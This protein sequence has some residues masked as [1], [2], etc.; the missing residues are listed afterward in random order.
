MRTSPLPN[1]VKL[2]A[3]A[4]SGAVAAGVIES[5][6]SVAR[7]LSEGAMAPGDWVGLGVRVAVYV[8]AAALIAGLV[9]GSRTARLALTGLLSV[10]GLAS[11]VVPAVAEIAGGS[12]V[13]AA[14][15][16][17]GGLFGAVFVV[18]R[19]VHIVLV[20]VATVA[21]YTP[22]ANAHFGHSRTMEPA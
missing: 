5:V 1:S 3:V 8:V 16:G 19:V 12:T 21:M 20:V 11:L 14:L 7:I 4:W 17:E 18:T 15:G 22:T 10:L 9:R 13:T 2:S 6:V